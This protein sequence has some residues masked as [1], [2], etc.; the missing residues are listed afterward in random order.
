MLR[1]VHC[2]HVKSKVCRNITKQH[3]VNLKSYKCNNL[4]F[5][6][7]IYLSVL[8]LMC[9]FKIINENLTASVV[10]TEI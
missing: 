3:I 2:L 1:G 7:L 5:L 10:I 4:K 8:M 6:T 9:V